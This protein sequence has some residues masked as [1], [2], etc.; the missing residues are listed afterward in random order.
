M[1]FDGKFEY[2]PVK[3]VYISSNEDIRIFPNPVSDM[4]NISGINDQPIEVVIRDI[5]G[6]EVFS[7][8]EFSSPSLDISALIDGIYTIYFV[9]DQR[10]I[11]Q[12]FVKQ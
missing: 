1:D 12:R 5:T 11:S 10:T 6:K 4:L 8:R 3:S 2:L 9:G 7:A